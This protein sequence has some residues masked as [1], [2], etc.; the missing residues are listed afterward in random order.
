MNDMMNR[1]S[2][3]N[4]VAVEETRAIAEVQA[5]VV[6][7]HKFPRVE[8]ACI[9]KIKKACAADSLAD[10][11]VA[12]YAYSRGTKPI[13]APS[14]RLAEAIAQNWNNLH[15]GI[16]EVM[17]GDDYSE[18]R[19]HSWDYENN[20]GKDVKFRAGHY[21]DTKNGKKRVT[22][23][24][25]IFEVITAAASKRARQCILAAV[26]LYVLD[27]A[28][29][30]VRAAIRAKQSGI[31]LSVRIAR[32][33][34]SFIKFNI[35]QEMVER[36]LG[37]ALKEINEED[38]E[39]M[40]AI[41]TSIKDGVTTVS[42]WFEGAAPAEATSASPLAGEL[43][44]EKQ[45]KGSTEP[46]ATEPAPQNAPGTTSEGKKVEP[47]AAT[48]GTTAGTNG[49]PDTGAGKNRKPMTK[50][51]PNFV[52][53]HPLKRFLLTGYRSKNNGK[54]IVGMPKEEKGIALYELH[55]LEP[56]ETPRHSPCLGS[57]VPGAP[58][59]IC[60]AWEKFYTFF[61]EARKNY[62]RIDEPDPAGAEADVSP[63]TP[64]QA[65][66]GSSTDTVP[67]CHTCLFSF[68]P[69]GQVIPC[70]R[71]VHG[72]PTNCE[73]YMNCEHKQAP[74]STHSKEKDPAESPNWDFNKRDLT[75]GLGYVQAYNQINP[76]NAKGAIGALPI[77]NTSDELIHVWLYD[78]VEHK[79]RTPV[80]GVPGFKTMPD[81]IEYLEADTDFWAKQ[82]NTEL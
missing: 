27:E 75:S 80:L 54:E 14:I 20:T 82:R 65:P 40:Y 61:E 53:G 68:S 37:K 1:E 58:R 16:E 4:M 23:E 49:Q 17:R 51:S 59:Y 66:A 69:E 2:A 24:R 62:V 9:K 57:A 70:T 12:F 72:D 36:H 8:E 74:E 55:F 44:K 71:G 81:V 67:P 15:Y 43:E 22:D 18:M 48:S 7:A 21:R 33:M 3:A 46:K 26:P 77:Y 50:S 13:M 60:D 10:E 76:I 31:P 41:F 19:V 30:S 64:D 73:K 63:K 38:L 78:R 32:M 39:A 34:K 42:E 28:V 5:K 11:E 35:S 25:D 29:A 79:A 6:M 52:D 45:G 47:P 56:G